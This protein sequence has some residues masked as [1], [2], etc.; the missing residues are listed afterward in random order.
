MFPWSDSGGT[1]NPGLDSD[2][3][4]EELKVTTQKGDGESSRKRS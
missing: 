4:C 2:L 3:G 1:T